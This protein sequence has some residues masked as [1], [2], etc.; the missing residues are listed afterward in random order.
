[1]HDLE[2]RGRLR[3]RKNRRPTKA[4]STSFF[5]ALARAPIGGGIYRTWRRPG[6]PA[7][8]I[9]QNLR[10][11]SP[12]LAATEEYHA[13]PGSHLLAALRDSAAADDARST[14]ELVRRISTALLTRSFRRHA[15][16]WE[17]NDEGDGAIPDI[18]PPTLGRGELHRPYFETL[19]VTGV[20]AERWPA[21]L[22]RVA[23]APPAA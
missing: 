15:G 5:Q 6:P 18:L 20:P 21:F 22:R 10:R 13:Y 12:E 8:T 23:Q 17:A 4:G 14:L 2:N 16:D 7:R 19:I 3:W 11:C 1:M 9:G